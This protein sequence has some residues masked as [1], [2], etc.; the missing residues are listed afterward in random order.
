[1]NRCSNPQCQYFPDP[2]WWTW[3]T[4]AVRGQLHPEIWRRGRLAD[5]KAR[6]E[7]RGSCQRQEP[8]AGIA[9]LVINLPD[10]HVATGRDVLFHYPHWV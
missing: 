8:G 6:R 4:G 5:R 10:P 2:D 9:V 7:R 1:M 3:S